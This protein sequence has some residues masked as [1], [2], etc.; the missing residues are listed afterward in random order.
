MQERTTAPHVRID[1]KPVPNVHY[2]EVALFSIL[3]YALSWLWWGIRLYPYLGSADLLGSVGTMDIV[4]GDFGPLIAAVIMRL[5]VS[6]EGLKGSL[7]LWRS[8][9]YFL[10]ALI[11]P[12]IF[13]GVVVG[14]SHLTGLGR[15][16]WRGDIPLWVYYPAMP[17]VGLIVAIF[18]FGEEYG[19]R[20]YLLPRVLPLG[21]IK[22]T[23]V[24]GVIWAGWHLPLLLIGFNYPGQSP[25]LAIPVFTFTVLFL[26]FPFTWFYVET[27]GSALLAAILHGVLNAYGDSMTAADVMRGNP[28]VVGSAGL[29]VGAFLMIITLV[30]YGIFKRPS[31]REDV[32]QLVRP[33]SD[34]TWRD[35]LR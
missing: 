14:F 21:E 31:R 18:V 26:S 28:L 29:I 25:W 32:G 19:W 7:G 2:R 9:K 33:Q 11:A 17:L 22:A 15:F 8:W 16:V 1:T 34:G 30:V 24:V 13:I 4:I 3:A 23:V 10:V 20:G 5:F 12:A 6:R 27:R 35:W